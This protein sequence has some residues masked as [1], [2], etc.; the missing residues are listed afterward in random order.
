MGLTV[1]PEKHVDQY[2]NTFADKRYQL[3]KLQEE[4]AELIV[5]CSKIKENNVRVGCKM[6]IVS[7]KEEI[8][9][10]LI[11]VDVVSKTYG[12]TVSDIMDEVLKKAKRH[13]FDIT[14]YEKK[15]LTFPEKL[16]LFTKVYNGLHLTL[17]DTS[18]TSCSDKTLSVEYRGLTVIKT[19]HYDSS[20]HDSWEL[21]LLNFLEE[22]IRIFELDGTQYKK[23]LKEANGR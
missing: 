18:I 14:S 2:C 9:H 17:D 6:P 5:A 22:V 20:R 7:L 15:P 1:V 19:F 13:N 16:T 4:C 12:I 3:D 8:T 21:M 23:A 11:S 10:V